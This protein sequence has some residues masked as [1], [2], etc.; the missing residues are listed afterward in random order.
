MAK[1]ITL[2]HQVRSGGWESMISANGGLPAHRYTPQMTKGLATG[3]R[4][5]FTVRVYPRVH[6]RPHP[7]SPRTPPAQDYEISP[8]P[9]MPPVPTTP[10]HP[11]TPLLRPRPRPQPGGVVAALD[12]HAALGAA[13]V[14]P[15]RAL[16]R[17]LGQPAPQGV[18]GE[19]PPPAGGV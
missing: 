16:P 5:G 18:G 6:I 10:S 15:S 19:P 12:P 7:L 3:V 1:P 9:A 2:S 13:K 14:G 11:P 4:T 8:R 17:G